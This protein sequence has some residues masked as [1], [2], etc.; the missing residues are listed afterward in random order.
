M[1]THLEP[2]PGQAAPVEVHE[3]IA[4]RLHVVSPTLL[5]AQVGV[6]A[7]IARRPRQVLVFSVGDV[8]PGTVVTVLLGQT[9]V[10]QENL[11]NTQGK[12]CGDCSSS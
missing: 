5:D 11:Q 2:L 1:S 9:K 6:D 4:Q 8:L 7:G 3:H 10:D 12:A